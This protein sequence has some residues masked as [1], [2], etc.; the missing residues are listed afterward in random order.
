MMTDVDYH[1]AGYVRCMGAYWAPPQRLGWCRVCAALDDW[2][3]I[4]VEY[5]DELNCGEMRRY[6]DASE[7]NP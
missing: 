5:V 7:H 6:T 1:A 3:I 2:K 4:M